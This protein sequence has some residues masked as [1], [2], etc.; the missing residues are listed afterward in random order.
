MEWFLPVSTE[1]VT[2]ELCDLLSKR[3]LPLMP[4]HNIQ[5]RQFPSLRIL[6]NI[7]KRQQGVY[8]EMPIRG[9]GL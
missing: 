7:L 5:E 2:M 9:D 4:C 1:H 3:H 6:V 8:C